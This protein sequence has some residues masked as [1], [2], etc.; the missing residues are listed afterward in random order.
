MQI[1]VITATLFLPVCLT[2]AAPHVFDFGTAK[3]PL[4]PGAVLVTE[5]DGDQAAWKTKQKRSTKVNAIQREWTTNKYSGKKVPP[6]SYQTELTCDYVYARHD[7]TLTI[8]VPPGAYKLLILSGRSHL[9]SEHVFDIRVTAAGGGTVS[10]TFAGSHELRALYLDTVAGQ[11]GISLNLTTRSQWLI[12]AL[13]AVPAAEWA[14]VHENTIKPIL[15]DCFML[16]PEELSKWIENPRPDT[17]PEPELTERQRQDGIIFYTRP[18]CEP[19]WPDHNPRQHEI[20]APLRAF[21]SWGEYEPLTFTLHALKDFAAINVNFSDLVN[22]ADVNRATIKAEIIDKRYVRYMYVRP[23]YNSFNTYYRAPDV[24]MPWQSQPLAKGEN[25]RLWLTVRIPLEQPEG[26]YHGRA[27][28]EA[29]G[30]KLDVPLMLRVLP[31]TLQKDQSLIYG[32][33]Y[34]QPLR[35]LNKAPDD[36]SR[37]W[38]QNK[39]AAEYRD[40]REHGMNTVVMG[41]SGWLVDNQWKFAFDWLQRDIDLARSVGFDKPFVCSISFNALYHKHMKA[42]TGSHL[43][44]VKMP[45]EEFFQEL[46]AMV[47]AIEAEARRRQWPELLYYPVDEPSTHPDAVAFMAHVLAAIKSVPNV[48]TYVTAD[49]DHEQFEMM[50]PYVDVWCCQPFSLGRD[51]VLADMKARGVE[52]W[53][54]PNHI[55]G[56]NDHTPTLGARMTYGFGFWQSGYRALIPWI[57]QASGGDPWNNLDYNTQD[58]FNRTADDGTPIP[59][60]LW[61]AYREGIDDHRYVYTL[62]NQIERVAA[63]GHTEEAAGAQAVLDQILKTMDV[64]TKYKNDGLW[65]PETFNT[66]RWMVA[67]KILALQKLPDKL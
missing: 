12:N 63:A 62:Q 11:E 43:R 48:R 65:S 16:P 59:V 44:L 38:W 17:T 32:Q 66:W 52:Y 5:S 55:S 2:L 1:K 25:L 60:T 15:A 41:L 10:A 35:N 20:N 26:I 29:D 30:V 6:P 8:A 19:V 51:A 28:V 47:R 22:T 54:Y 34:R 23:N 61:E 13:I 64:L 58:F 7:E 49:P 4:H 9:R 39:A 33:Y 27:T 42:S 36:F 24:L 53:C 40:M 50:R 37:A 56:E 14:A 21:A 46:T 45:P 18:W 31:I 3:S 67:E 57:Y